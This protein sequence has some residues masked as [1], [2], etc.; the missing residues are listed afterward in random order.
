MMKQKSTAKNQC[1]DAKE[2]KS[3]QINMKG[4]QHHLTA[5]QRD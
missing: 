5:N 4:G 3:I 2:Q 1:H